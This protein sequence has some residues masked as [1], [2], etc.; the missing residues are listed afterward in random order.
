MVQGLQYSDLHLLRSN[1]LFQIIQKKEILQQVKKA[2]SLARREILA[3]MLLKEE[4]VNPL[5]VSYFNLLN[6]K[7]GKGIMLKRLGFGRKED[8]NNIK[9][10]YNFR[11]NSK[12]RY[13]I[14]ESKYQRL[15]I[16]DKEKL[17]FGIDGLYFTSRHKPLIEVFVDYFYRNFKKGKI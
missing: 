8:Y 9:S 2:I 5:P 10:R 11:N 15:I 7:M 4:I 12:F 17:F 6:K 3:T 14:Q 16:I 1:M 13:N